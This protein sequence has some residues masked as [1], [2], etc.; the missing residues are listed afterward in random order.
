MSFRRS[1]GGIA[2]ELLMALLL[3]TY[4]AAWGQ[5]VPR[6]DEA[7]PAAEMPPPGP[8]EVLPATGIDAPIHLPPADYEEYAAPAA[9][10]CCFHYGLKARSFYINDQRIEF[11]GMEATFAVEGV[12]DAGFH[13]QVGEWEC[14]AEAELFLNQP[15][16]RNVFI[17]DEFRRSFA[18]NFDVDILQISQLYLAAQRNDLYLAAGRIVTPFGRFYFPNYLNTFADSPFLRS[19]AILFRETGVMARW[20]PGVYSFTAA[21]TN[22]GPERDGNSSK[23]LIARIGLDWEQFSIGSSI[24]A[25]DGIGSEN[26]KAYNRHLGVDAC[27]RGG[28]WTLSGEVLYDEYGMRRPGL[29]LTDIFWGRSIYFRESHNPSGGPLTGVGYYIDLGYESACWTCHLNYGDYFPLQT[30]GVSAHDTAIHRGLIKAAYRITPLWETYGIVLLEN[31]ASF[32]KR[33]RTG[34]AIIAGVQFQL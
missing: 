9:D 25:Q 18:R 30:L 27:L 34:T 4:S 15:Y 17:N 5:N 23:A 7:A 31:D 33:S 24:K 1:F 22:G 21:L 10:A 26:Q 29:A 8:W 2:V 28:A 3:L 13:Q 19:E 12:A 16:D 14:M 32:G 6:D 11:T 20:E